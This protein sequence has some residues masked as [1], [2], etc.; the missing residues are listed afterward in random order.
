MK[1]YPHPIERCCEDNEN[2]WRQAIRH[3]HFDGKR[4]IATNGRVLVIAPHEGDEGD[5]PGL[6]P[7]EAFKAMRKWKRALERGRMILNDKVRV[8]G[9]GAV[10]YDRPEDDGFPN[11]DQI[12]RRAGECGIAVTF[13]VDARLLLALQ[14]AMGTNSIEIS[15]PVPTEGRLRPQVQDPLIVKTVGLKDGQPYGFVMPIVLE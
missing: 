9:K 2:T 14:E 3:V 13:G 15:A 11:V 8:E 10:E 4:L 6:V 7:A 12:E 5:R 1:I